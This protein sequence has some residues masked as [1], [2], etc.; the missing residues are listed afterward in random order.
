MGIYSTYHDHT[1]PNTNYWAGMD[2]TSMA[3]GVGALIWSHNPSWT[4]AQ[5]TS[6][7]YSSADNID[8]YLSSK[9]IGKM[10]AGRIN[11]YN[12]VNTGPPPPPVAQFSGSPTS[13]TVPLTVNF[14]DLSTG[15]ITSW[16]WTFGDGGTSIAQNPSHQYT[17]TGIYTVSLTVTGP[18]GS[19]GETKNNYITVSPCVAPTANFVGSPTSGDAPL[20]V[21]FT[22]Q[23]SGSPT[24][25]SW[26]FGDSGTSTAQNPSHVY[27]GA[28]TYTVTLTVSNACGSDQEV[29]TNYITVTASQQQCDDFNDGNISNWGNK[30][31]TWTA[32]GGYM[33][34]NSNTS[35]ARTTSP[36]GSTSINCD[37]RMNTGR[38]SRIA[39]I[40][41]AYTD[42]NNYRFAQFDDVANRVRIYDRVS[43]SNSLK[44]SANVSMSSG[45]WY[46]VAVNVAAGGT[47]SI[48][49]GANTLLSY[50]FGNV[51]SG[52][53][54]V[55]F[56]RSNSD[57]D[58]FC[59]GASG[60][61]GLASL[62]DENMKLLADE[63]MP[64]SF[65]LDQNYPNPFNPV[66][67]FTL[68]L[69]GETRVSVMVFNIAGQRVRTLLDEV[70]PAGSHTL[71]WDGTND[72][73][74]ALA[75]GVYLYRVVAGNET[76]T[77]K[78]TLLR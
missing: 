5:V 68:N 40:I 17:S 45:V 51:I 19:D 28:G 33:K 56:D 62:G 22:D 38:T 73:G 21:N 50:N 14:T 13:G 8:A 43:G 15:S 11:A 66:T 48:T 1:D 60:L 30:L 74:E 4:A 35:N 25:W 39:R 26:N 27:T 20:T 75:S 76:L 16:R 64:E 49:S 34:G 9:Y 32:T 59:V 6:Q 3:A 67:Q 7:L 12:A 65:S 47:V 41:F 55:G 24:S 31:G 54:G 69:T 63:V 58:N 42:G 44:A 52:L 36:F 71:T 29:K 78:M 72:M 77:R 46:S 37:I 53:V 23:S 70:M 10:G 18:G 57:F 61:S 2:G